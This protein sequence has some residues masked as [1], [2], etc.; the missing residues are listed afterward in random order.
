MTLVKVKK[1][2]QVTIPQKLRQKLKLAVGD[3]ME[4]EVKGNELVFKVVKLIHPGQEYFYSAEWQKG[5]AQA[6]KDIANGDVTGPFSFIED[7]LRAL[8][9]S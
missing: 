6:D 3:F 8:K 9:K 2:Y 4:L 5:E 1:N 7:G